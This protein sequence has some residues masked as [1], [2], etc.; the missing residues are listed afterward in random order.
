MKLVHSIMWAFVVLRIAALSVLAWRGSFV[1]ATWLAGIVG[2]CA[3]ADT[4]ALQW[5]NRLDSPVGGVCDARD[6]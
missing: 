6:P 3:R 1:A 5:D 4:L 2:S